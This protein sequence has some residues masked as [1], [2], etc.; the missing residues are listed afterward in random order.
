MS[1]KRVAS[2]AAITVTMGLIIACADK[3]VAPR[4]ERIVPFAIP[5]EQRAMLSATLGIASQD[6]ALN[7]LADRD[8]AARIATALARLASRVSQNDAR[9]AREAVED[10]RGAVVAYRHQTPGDVAGSMV[11]EVIEIATEHVV[12]AVEEQPQAL[13]QA[14]R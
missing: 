7:A 3:V 5:E 8:A 14:T 10:V 2:G 11:L 1:A 13:Y 9:G 12:R 4:S 6:E